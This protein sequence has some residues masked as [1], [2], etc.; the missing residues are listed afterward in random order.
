MNKLPLAT[1]VQILSMPCGWSSIR[2]ISRVADLSINTVFKLLI[3]EGKACP[4]FNGD[5][6]SSKL[7]SMTEF[8]ETIDAAQ[9]KPGKRG[10]QE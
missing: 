4:A 5:T 1:C 2:L 9:Q 8:A 6:M 10:T 3:D 7:W